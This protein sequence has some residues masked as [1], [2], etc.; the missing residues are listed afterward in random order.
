MW[1][2]SLVVA[3]AACGSVGTRPVVED[4]AMSDSAMPNLPFPSDGSEGAFAPAS[5]VT[6]TSGIHQY[7]TID[8]PMGVTVTV[9]GSGVLELRAQQAIRIAGNIN[10]SGAPGRLAKDVFGNGGGNT[11]NPSLQGADGTSS[12]CPGGGGGG[13]GAIGRQ[14]GGGACGDSLGSPGGQFG[15][16]AGGAYRGSGGGG[17]GYAGGAGGGTTLSAGG[18]GASLN[19]TGGAGGTAGGAGGQSDGGSYAGGVGGSNALGA[20]G[21]GGGSIGRAA[22]DDLAV[23]TTFQPGSGG[24][25][26]SGR[27]AAPNVPPANLIVGGTGGGGGGG[28][29]RIA[30]AVSI[31]IGAMAQIRSDGGAGGDTNQMPG[32]GGGGGSGGVIYLSAPSLQVAG[33]VS[34]V[35]GPGGGPSAP[36]GLGGL[37]RIRLSV[38]PAHCALTGTFKPELMAGCNPSVGGGMPDHVFI[39]AFPD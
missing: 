28:A 33:S 18:A 1:A 36:G 19:G 31:E 4:S 6:L 26:G 27:A 9:N 14:V 22:I 32:G 7:T 34:S 13:V 39:A 35:G 29:L 23:K 3:L 21:G 5:D 15:G 10:L 8:I 24:G 12:T 25:G 38:D 17:G 16:G 37:G 30:S 11:G 2:G 20:T